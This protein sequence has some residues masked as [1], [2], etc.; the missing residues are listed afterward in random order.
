[1]TTRTARRD[2]ANLNYGAEATEAR[3]EAAQP[4][5]EAAV[6]SDPHGESMQKFQD[7]FAEQHPEAQRM[8]AD[9]KADP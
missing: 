7:N 1:M 4:A 3:P 8:L 9:Y 2:R 6:N 5:N